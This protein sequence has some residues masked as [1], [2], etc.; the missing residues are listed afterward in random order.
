[1]AT[2]LLGGCT[3]QY[4]KHWDLEVDSNAYTLSYSD[5]SFPLFVY[6]SGM[7]HA[8]FDADVDWISIQEGSES[9]HGN[10]IVRIS[11]RYNEFELR[12]VNLVITS[13]EFT[14]TVAITQKYDTIH[15]EVE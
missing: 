4:E 6:C 14:Q 2:L 7:W 9:G 5:G 11:Y 8:S 15:M 13:G 12:T 1:M 3:K 10:G